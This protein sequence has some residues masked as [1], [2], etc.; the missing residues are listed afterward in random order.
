LGAALHR[1]PGE[2]GKRPALTVCGPQKA[3][4]AFNPSP[5]P[6]SPHRS[7]ISELADS[8]FAVVFP[9]KCSICN[10]EVACVSGLGVCQACW[11]GVEPWEG[12]ACERC[13]IPIV[14]DRAADALRVLC[15][16]CRA[17]LPDF[18][19]ARSYGIYRGNLRQLIL[20][21]KFRR[22]ERLGRKLGTLLAHAWQ[23]L[24]GFDPANPP[25]IAPVPL[26]HSRERER[27]FN[28]SRLLA[29]GLRNRIEKLPGGIKIGLD[30]HLLVRTRATSPQARLKFQARKENVRG[31]FAVG[32][33][34]SVRG[35]HIILVDDVMTTG[36]TLSACA[37]ALKKAGAAKVAALALARATPLFPDHEVLPHP[38]GVDEFNRDWT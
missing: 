22:R 4:L 24:G 2:T 18:D 16:E 33:P 19:V 5:V 34:E 15:G 31:A 3:R 1:V 29:E 7:L 9:T 14:S 28:Q 20:Q 35:R 30:A 12:I 27:G 6:I 11:A 13:G 37:A 23:K 38:P 10:G 21:L 36:A 32:K 25:L 8:L 26:F 17:D